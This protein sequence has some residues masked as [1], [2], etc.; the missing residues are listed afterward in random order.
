M[1]EAL[2]KRQI[3]LSFAHF[4]TLFNVFCEPGI[5]GAGL[6]RR[7]MVSAQTM[8]AILRRLERD[9]RIQRRPHP[10]SRRADSWF[11]TDTGAAL[12]ERARVVGDTVFEQMLSALK[13]E[14]AE[15][16][17]GYLRRCIKALETGGMDLAPGCANARRMVN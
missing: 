16:L 17:L 1:E 12:L 8:N 5:N 14:E 3:D 13:A 10:D 6:A 11:I 7:S 15:R 2:R 4:V 9:G